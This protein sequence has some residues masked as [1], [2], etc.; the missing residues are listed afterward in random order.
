[1]HKKYKIHYFIRLFLSLNIF[2]F[3]FFIIFFSGFSVTEVNASTW[4]FSGGNSYT[5]GTIKIS[6]SDKNVIYAHGNKPSGETDFLKSINSGT[7][8]FSSLGDLP[9]NPDINSIAIHPNNPDIVYIGIYDKGVYL[10]KDGGETWSNINTSE[11]EGKFIRSL[12]ID[13]NNPYIL[14]VGT[15]KTR[16]D[17]G[18]YKSTNG[19]KN[20][21]VKEKNIGKPNIMQIVISP[22]NSNIVYVSAD[23]VWKSEDG[24]ETWNISLNQEVSTALAIDP[25]N[26]KIIYAGPVNDGIYKTTNEGASWNKISQGLGNKRIHCIVVNPL[27]NNQV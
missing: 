1:M 20:W 17:G 16:L 3:I 27:D 12:A 10:T 7:T 14:F 9:Q 5:V 19:G 11:L 13:T 4:I 24:G 25:I 18:I 23:K 21:V 15:G 22:H 26:H 2:F 8:W 6:K